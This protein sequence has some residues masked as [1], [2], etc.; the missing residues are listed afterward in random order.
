MSEL[1]VD[2]MKEQRT[3]RALARV[4]TQQ[5]MTKYSHGKKKEA[6]KQTRP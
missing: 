4:L 2:R 1:V 5:Q 6:K 3:R